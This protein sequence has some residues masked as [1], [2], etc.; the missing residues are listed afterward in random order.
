MLPG[1]RL[2]ARLPI[3]SHIYQPLK[4]KNYNIKDFNVKTEAKMCNPNLNATINFYALYT[5]DF[6]CII[7]CRL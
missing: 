1:L 3:Y 2:K 5:N 4:V 6:H 7:S